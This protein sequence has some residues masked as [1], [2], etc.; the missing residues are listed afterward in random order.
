MLL[1]EPSHFQQFPVSQLSLDFIVQLAK[2]IPGIQ[3]WVGEFA[4]LQSLYPCAG[5]MFKEHPLFS[6]Y[7]GQQDDRDWMFPQVKGYYPSFFSYWKKCERYL[8]DYNPQLT[9]FV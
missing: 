6:H 5:F 2:N 4:G 9:L 7:Q 3:V 8:N 1:L